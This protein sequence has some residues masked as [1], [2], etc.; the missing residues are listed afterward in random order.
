M[1]KII[2]KAVIIPTFS[3]LKFKYSQRKISPELHHANYQRVILTSF[4]RKQRQLKLDHD[5]V[6]TYFI[7]RFINSLI[8]DHV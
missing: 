8:F 2:M 3:I 4:D 5:E 7:S 1:Q 6:F